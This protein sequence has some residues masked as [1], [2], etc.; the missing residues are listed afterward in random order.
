MSRYYGFC[1]NEREHEDQARRDAQYD[2]RD[3]EMYDRHT[4]DPCKEAYTETYDR[5]RRNIER[6]EEERE[7]E[8]QEEVH[9][10]HMAERRRAEQIDIE[11]EYV[12]ERYYE[13]H[14]EQEEEL[15]PAPETPDPVPGI[16]GVEGE[17][18][19]RESR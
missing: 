3:Y 13:Q 2:R 1:W 12:R 18:H 6:R 7:Q 4:S 11:Q 10:Q 16:Q 14:P 19:G 9:Q 15:V 17:P 8:R 5:E